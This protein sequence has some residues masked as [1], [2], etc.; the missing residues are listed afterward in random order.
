MES[1][2]RPPPLA[3]LC[4]S[5][6]PLLLTVED[7]YMTS[8]DLRSIRV[9]WQDFLHPFVAVKN[10]YLSSEILPYIGP[11]LQKLDRE[12][13]TDVLPVPQCLFLEDLEKL[14]TSGPDREA[15]LRLSGHPISVSLWRGQ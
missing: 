10:L 15:I 11:A 2:W 13:G 5:L 1:D 4:T 9:E 12:R 7:L 14:R 3:R 8:P 6:L